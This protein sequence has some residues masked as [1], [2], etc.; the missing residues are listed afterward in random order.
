V[1]V[2]GD[3]PF[4][5]KNSSVVDQDVQVGVVGPYLFGQPAHLAERGE[6]GPVATE[7]KVVRL[8]ADLA[9]RDLHALL[10]SSV[11]KYRGPGSG[12]VAGDSPPEPVGG[13]GDQDRRFICICR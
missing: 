1:A 13:A 9:H 8:L 3:G 2:P 10:V 6:V 5:G 4:S 12:Q 11:Q 7:L